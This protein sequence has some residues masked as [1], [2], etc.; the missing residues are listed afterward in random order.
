MGVFISSTSHTDVQFLQIDIVQSHV[1]ANFSPHKCHF[2]GH[3]LDGSMILFP[4]KY[5]TS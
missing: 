3:A 5:Q 2:C 1:V 4:M